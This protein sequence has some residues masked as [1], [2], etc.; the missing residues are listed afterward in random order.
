MQDLFS[1]NDGIGPVYA[2]SHLVVTR[3]RE[4]TGLRFAGEIDISNSEAI[5]QSMR[6]ALGN[7]ARSH[8]DL[9]GLSF[10]DVSGIRALVETAIDLGD[11]RQMLLH[12]L[13]RQLQTVM[14]ITGWADEA[15]LTLCDCKVAAR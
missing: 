14:R 11:G 7:V 6:I 10:I 5:A 4:P 3:T 13:P 15:T 12:G 8:L 9:S 2:D 1:S